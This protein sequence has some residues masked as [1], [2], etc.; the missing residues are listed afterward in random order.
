[1]PLHSVLALFDLFR[2][3]LP[4]GAGGEEEAGRFVRAAAH[5]ARAD[6]TVT[7]RDCKVQQANS[8]LLTLWHADARRE[9]VELLNRLEQCLAQHCVAEPAVAGRRARIMTH[10]LERIEEQRKG[11]LAVRRALHLEEPLVGNRGGEASLDVLPAADA[12]VVHPHETVVAEGV[13]VLVREVALGGGADMGEDERGAGLGCQALE[14]QAVP[15][16]DGRGED[17]WLRAKFG[18]GVVANAEA[19]AVVRP[20]GILGW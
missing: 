3:R 12:A 15:S 11:P 5:V 17:A 9:L 13:A 16:G 18:V 4:A 8:V 6:D 2:G 7:V 19:I 20:A 14:V 10:A 1:M